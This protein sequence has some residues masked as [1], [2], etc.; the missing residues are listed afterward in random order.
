M[1]FH[2]E[3]YRYTSRIRLIWDHDRLLGTF[4]L[5]VFNGSFVIDPGPGQDHFKADVE[6]SKFHEALA[7]IK[8][9]VKR[10]SFQMAWNKC[11]IPHKSFNSAFTI[12]K[13]RFG[14]GKIWGHFE[15]MS[16]VGY[17]GG[18]HVCSKFIDKWNGYAETEEDEIPR[19]P[20]PRSTIAKSP[21]EHDDTYSTGSL[22]D[23]TSQLKEWT[24]KD[25]QSF[26]EM[27]TGIYD[28]TSREIEEDWLSTSKGL[29]ARLHV[30]QQQGKVLGYFDIGIVEGFLCL[31]DSLEA[32]THN[33][34]WNSNGTDEVPSPAQ[35]NKAPAHW[36]S[37]AEAQEQSR[38]VL[39]YA[40]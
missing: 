5:D 19:S 25:Q 6:Y 20:T 38:Y 12:G 36:P 37:E 32:L 21:S 24:E 30:D 29:M 10:V 3:Y 40:G 2:D 7:K 18:R 34:P 15:A 23:D 14:N 26:I 4:D 39:R 31:N 16:G 17:P 8:N 11:K 35:P 13:I 28:I 9:R 22:M 27:I 1:V 33:S